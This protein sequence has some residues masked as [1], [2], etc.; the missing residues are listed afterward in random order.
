MREEK[1][2]EGRVSED[3]G[4]ESEREQNEEKIKRRAPRRSDL[5]ADQ[6]FFDG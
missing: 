1:E 2:S 5:E 3:R 6:L 4:R